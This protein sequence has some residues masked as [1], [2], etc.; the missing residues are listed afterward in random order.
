MRDCLL[1]YFIFFTSGGINVT[2]TGKNLDSVAEPIMEV[3]ATKN[4]D[5]K[6]NKYYQVF[7]CT[8]IMGIIQGLRHKII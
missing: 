4:K 6:S 3:R 8:L 1:F 5:G 2:C 7:N